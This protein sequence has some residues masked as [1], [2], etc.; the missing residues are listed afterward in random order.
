M[1]V[2]FI[3]PA[4][5]NQFTALAHYLGRV[6][7]YETAF[8][9]DMGQ[10]SQIQKDAVPI[11]Y[12]GYS[13]DGGIENPCWYVSC[14]ED[15][16]RHGKGVA[17]TLPS[18][19]DIFPA[20]LVIGHASFGT[21][22]YIRE[23]F[24]LPVISYVEL[25]GYHMAWCRSE[26]PALQEHLYLNSSFQSL[27][28]SAAMKSDAVLVP[29]SHARDF[30]PPEIRDKVH[31]RMEGFE[32]PPLYSDKKTL[33]IEAGLPEDG[34]IIGFASRTLE[35]VRGFDVFVK[36]AERL[37]KIRPDVHFLVIGSEQTLYGNELTYLEGKSFKRHML[38]S[39]NL[40]DDFFIFKDY[41][42]YDDYHKHLQAMDQIFFP[43][44]EGAANWGLFEA[45]ASGLPVI[46]SD[47]CFIPEVIRQG[48]NG[49][50]VDPQDLDSMVDLS[51]YLLNDP[52][53]ADRIGKNARN[54]IR[55]YYSVEQ[56]VA[57]YLSVIDAVMEQAS[58]LAKHV[59]C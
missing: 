47:R 36:I 50:M 26:Y 38:D 49:W 13:R 19:L 43:Q 25:P 12:F 41:L 2:L 22:F 58:S 1:K 23:M 40:P 14:Y 52:G 7:G 51:L 31:V 29:S 24:N 27:V 18:V 34:P 5:P 42:N 53:T 28:F 17:D 20:D 44:F 30:F 16:L 33:R 4:Y 3:H 21:T 32:L 57:G 9:T 8:L 56:S 45:M 11:P 59:A 39:M 48:V 54:T 15:A 37:K 35:A 6:Q 55:D 10:A 46:A